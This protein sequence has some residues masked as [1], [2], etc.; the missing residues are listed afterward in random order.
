MEGWLL[1]P[2]ISSPDLGQSLGLD[3]AQVQSPEV[4]LGG[5]TP[6]KSLENM[7]IPRCQGLSMVKEWALLIKPGTVAAGPEVLEIT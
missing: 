3:P 2:E 6:D 4:S 7:Q 5:L 1:L